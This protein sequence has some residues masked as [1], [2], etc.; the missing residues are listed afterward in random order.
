MSTPVICF[1]QQPN[2]IFP[3]RYLYAK[4]QTAKKLQKEI[5]G[6]IVFF[7]HDSDA[8]YRETITL[9]KDKINGEDMRLNFIQENK[10][11]KKYSPLYVKKIVAGWQE[12]II[13]KLPRLVPKELID[14]FS[15]IHEGTVA[16]FCLSVYKKMGFFDGIEIVRSGDKSFRMEAEDL[17][18]YY[19]DVE[20]EGEIVRAE[21]SEGILRLHEGGG[22]YITIPT[23]AKIEKWQKNPGRDERFHWMQSVIGATHYIAGKGEMAYLTRENFPEVMFVE[24]DDI[25]DQNYAYIEL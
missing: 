15:S 19:A 7:Y 3:K 25:S 2:G 23:P 16:D 9:L 11:Q 14:L 20:Y 18:T 24:R 6:R 21:M 8:D 22:N 10:I 5:G 12:E 17:T 13:K 4:I 1:G